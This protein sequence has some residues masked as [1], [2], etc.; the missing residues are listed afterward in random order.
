MKAWGG[1]ANWVRGREGDYIGDRESR[2]GKREVREVHG[3][4]KPQGGGGFCKF[5][6]CIPPREF[7]H[8]L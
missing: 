6:G 4:G 1:V 5:K 3:V 7:F 8:E 2:G